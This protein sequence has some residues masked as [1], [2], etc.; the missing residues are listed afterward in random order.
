MNST[1]IT[2]QNIWKGL[3][4]GFTVFEIVNIRKCGLIKL[5]W[6][7]I[8]CPIFHCWYVGNLKSYFSPIVNSR[9]PSITMWPY[10]C[11]HI[12]FTL[13][14]FEQSVSAVLQTVY[15]FSDSFILFDRFNWNLMSALMVNF[16]GVDHYSRGRPFVLNSNWMK[17]V[18]WFRPQA[19][20][21]T[22][23]EDTALGHPIEGRFLNE[24]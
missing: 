21:I 14:I 11:Y 13:F 12:L 22:K 1:P 20:R 4:Y 16:A 3:W 18:V 9:G 15:T 6:S 19:G 24:Y 5:N 23:G 8:Q 2:I 10:E 7:L 17:S